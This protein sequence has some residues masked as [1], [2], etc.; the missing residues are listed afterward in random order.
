MKTQIK[1][2]R[3]GLKNQIL[4][5]NQLN[6]NV[7]Q[8]GSNVIDVHNVWIKITSENPQSIKIKVMGIEAEL[9]ANWSLSGK[10]VNYVGSIESDKL[11]QTFNLVPS[12][13]TT[14]YVQI[15]FGNSIKVSNGKNSYI[16]VCPSLVEII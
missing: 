15:D 4:A 9:T 3:S 6:S 1:N 8:S 14:P 2:L 12:K 13:K 7:G 16:Y 10:S 11:E 5:N